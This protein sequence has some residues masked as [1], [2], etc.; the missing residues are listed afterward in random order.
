MASQ[1]DRIGNLENSLTQLADGMTVL[2][3]QATAQEKELNAKQSLRKEYNTKRDAICKE[4]D[5]AL[6]AL[7]EEYA[8]QFKKLNVGIENAGETTGKVLAIGISP[9]QNFFTGVK[10][11]F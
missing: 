11:N 5:E 1:E 6:E 4:A 3:S 7:K 10:K 8:P 9:F 2:V